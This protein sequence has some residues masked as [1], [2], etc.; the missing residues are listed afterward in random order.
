[1]ATLS[2]TRDRARSGPILVVDDDARFRELVT[3]ILKR[4]RY[5]AAYDRVA[6]LLVGRDD[7]LVKPFA[8]D[9]LLARVG[10]LS[11][12]AR[13]ATPAGLTSEERSLVRLLREGLGAGEIAQRLRE[14]QNTVRGRVDEVLTKLGV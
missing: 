10:A 9:E 13:E 14:T 3:T 7:Y 12:R 11:R 8:P 2:V 4:A 1:V 5:R 6:G